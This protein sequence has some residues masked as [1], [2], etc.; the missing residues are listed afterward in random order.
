M[1]TINTD[2]YIKKIESNGQ[3]IEEYIKTQ[4]NKNKLKKITPSKIKSKFYDETKALWDANNKIV[5][6]YYKN[7]ENDRKLKEKYGFWFIAILAFQLVCL[8]VILFLVGLG[9]L[10]YSDT[11]LNIFISG[12]LIETFAVIKVI[13]TYLFNDN[14]SNSIKTILENNKNNKQDKIDDE[15]DVLD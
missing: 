14:L 11:T 10:T 4:F 6:L 2:E 15:T 13:I 7:A 12:G 3:S 5:D 1:S 9:I 8:Y